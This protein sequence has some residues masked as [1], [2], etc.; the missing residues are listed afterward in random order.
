VK[1]QPL[2]GNNLSEAIAIVACLN[3]RDGWIHPRLS[4]FLLRWAELHGR[5]SV[6]FVYNYRP[7]HNAR[8]KA[9]DVFMASDAEWAFLIDNDTCPPFACADLPAKLHGSEMGVIG[10]PYPCLFVKDG[11]VRISDSVTVI[12]GDQ[13]VP[14]ILPAS[15]FHEVDVVGTGAMFVSR[16]VFEKMQ[17]PWFRSTDCKTDPLDDLGFCVRAKREGVKICATSDCGRAEHFKSVPLSML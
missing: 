3:E 11:K 4:T 2:R 1:G 7:H 17:Q 13:T 6:N 12:K 10:I 14:F 5:G 9:A 15:G 16:S 8:N